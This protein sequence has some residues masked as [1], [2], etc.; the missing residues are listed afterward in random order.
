MTGPRSC[1]SCAVRDEAL[2]RALTRE[3]LALLNRSGQWRR[4]ARGDV[5]F[6]PGDRGVCGNLVEGVLKLADVTADGDSQT[7]A[8]LFPGD[9]VGGGT[10][11]HDIVALSPAQLC[12]FP[13]RAFDQALDSNREM[14]RLLLARTLEAMDAARSWLTLVLRGS[15]DERVGHL[16]A[17]LADRAGSRSFDLPIT[18]GDI[19]DALGL[20]L[21]TVSRVM[22]RMKADGRLQVDGRRRVRLSGHLA[23]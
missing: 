12:L 20:T 8:L 13:Q 17:R 18:R 1:D 10:V 6:R 9:F 15:A 14:E 3:Q 7:V 16:L 5:L 21:E 4:L 2:C 23:A 19:A 22:A 11:R